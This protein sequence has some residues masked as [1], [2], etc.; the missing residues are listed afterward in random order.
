[1]K[2]RGQTDN[3]NLKIQNV[4]FESKFLLLRAN[5]RTFIKHIYST[6]SDISKLTNQTIDTPAV[7]NAEQAQLYQKTKE[8]KKSV[9][10]S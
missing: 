7:V 5:I 1:M 9:G 4:F 2:Y 6:H 8:D 3:T 10:I